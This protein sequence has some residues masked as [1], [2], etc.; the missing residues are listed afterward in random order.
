[1]EREIPKIQAEAKEDILWVQNNI[2]QVAL[3]KVQKHLGNDTDPQ[4]RETVTNLVKKVII[5]TTLFIIIIIII[6]FFLCFMIIVIITRPFRVPIFLNTS[7]VC[8]IFKVG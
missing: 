8:F 5:T 4:F 3:E 2:Y 7:F 6:T 1:M